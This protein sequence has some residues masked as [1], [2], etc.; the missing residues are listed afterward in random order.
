MLYIVCLYHCIRDQSIIC[1]LLF[2][3]ILAD[4]LCTVLLFVTIVFIDVQLTFVYV[5]VAAHAVT[6]NADW[7]LMLIHYVQ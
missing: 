1:L 5:V 4:H 7:W 2:F 3:F 6:M